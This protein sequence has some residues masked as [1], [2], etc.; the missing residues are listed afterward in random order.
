MLIRQAPGLH[1][2]YDVLY[3]FV[4]ITPWEK[5]LIDS[6][7]FQRLRWIKQLGFAHYVFPGAEHTR[8]A[9]AIGVMH[10]MHQMLQ[11][12]GLAVSDQDLAN[13][14]CQNPNAILH[15][16]LRVA[17]LL[18]DIGTFPFSHAIEHAY[19]RYGIKHPLEQGKD[20][21]NSHEHL[22]SFLIKNTPFPGGL[23]F[24]LEQAG[25]DVQR[26]SHMI[27]GEDQEAIANQ[28]MHSDL[29]ADRMDYLRRDAHHTGIHYGQFDRDYLLANLTLFE[30]HTD[31]SQLHFGIQENALHA[32][33]DF[34]FARFCWYTQVIK[35]SDSAKFDILSSH[36]TEALLEN[37]QLISFAELLDQITSGDERFFGWN[38]IFWMQRCQTL[39]LSAL[40]NRGVLSPLLMDWLRRILYRHPP[41]TLEHPLLEAQLFKTPQEKQEHLKKIDLLLDPFQQKIQTCRPEEAWVLVDLPEKDISFCTTGSLS[42]RDPIRLVSRKGTP[43]LLTERKNAMSNSLKE[44]RQFIPSLY[45][46]ENT[47]RLWDTV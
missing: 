7:F 29:D 2:V 46:H 15:K 39:Y 18:H 22:G 45:T 42:Q 31:G 32:I 13:P 44:V 23:T 47:A 35:H 27:K 10:S 9:H 6:P 43:S 25:F 8:F 40:E 33:E 26:L 5:Q 36:I 24:I 28:L 17:A 3:G 16:H 34:L 19:I 11:A 20:L 4:P 1:R 30:L 37:K 14:A 12:L 21:P 41:K 38:D